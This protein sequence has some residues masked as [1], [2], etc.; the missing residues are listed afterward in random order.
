[1]FLKKRKK[2][3]KFTGVKRRCWSHFFIE[4]PAEEQQPYL[5]ETPAQIFFRGNRETFKRTFL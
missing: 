3:A 5:K 2:I 1:M 4:F